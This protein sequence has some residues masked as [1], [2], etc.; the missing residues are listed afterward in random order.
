MK[1]KRF[2]KKLRNPSGQALA[3]TVLLITLISA[4]A[5]G[6]FAIAGSTT[7][8]I[9]SDAAELLG[10][11]GSDPYD[12]SNVS[13]AEIP[14]QTYTGEPVE[15]ELEVTAPDGAALVGGTDYT[16]E[17]LNNTDLGTATAVLTGAGEWHGSRSADFN[18]VGAV[19]EAVPTQSGTL[20][21]RGSAQSPSWSGFDS[22]MLSVSGDTSGTNAGSYTAQFTPKYGYVWADGTCGAKSAVWTIGKLDLNNATVSCS[23]ISDWMTGVSKQ[24]SPRV[25]SNGI[26]V[27]SSLYTVSYSTPDPGTTSPYRSNCS[28]TVTA[29]NANVTG[30]KTASYTVTRKMYYVYYNANGGSGAPSMQSKAYD[31]NLTLSSTKPTRSG[32][33]F[34]GWGIQSTSTSATYQA[35]DTY[36]NNSDWT[37]YAVWKESVNVNTTLAWSQAN[38]RTAYANYVK[39]L[40]KTWIVIGCNGNGVYSASNTVTLLLADVGGYATYA[41]A[42]QTAN[43]TSSGQ[44]T[45][46]QNYWNNIKTSDSKQAN[47]VQARTL[48]HGSYSSSSPWCNGIPDS[49][50]L[51]SQYLWPLSTAEAVML[52][53][54]GTAQTGLNHGIV[55]AQS[56]SVTQASSWWWLRSPG[57]Y[58]DMAAYCYG[59]GAVATDGVSEVLMGGNASSYQIRPALRA[60]TNSLTIT[61]G[62][63]TRSN[64][65][66]LAAS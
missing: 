45:A 40:G 3:E 57:N 22:T 7:G 61:S 42:G 36:R 63:G 13:I 51:S 39:F 64:P 14:D 15:P 48:E 54:N 50:S 18:I 30:S 59:D 25:I 46:M 5:I 62:S 55:S 65:Y 23:N 16:V 43:Y 6:G 11:D 47:L 66:V 34:V 31:V 33:D 27:S 1:V 8:G 49:S 58:S 52:A 56:D 26:T 17:Y 10:G 53:G 28:A 24:S 35:G 21:Y 19:I 2:M 9:L 38:T 41:I 44:R 32:Y 60:S 4:L 37:L 20:T 12:F 29:A